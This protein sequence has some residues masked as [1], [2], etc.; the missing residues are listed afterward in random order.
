MPTRRNRISGCCRRFAGREAL[1][2]PSN[3]WR[4]AGAQRRELRNGQFVPDKSNGL[5]GGIAV[6]DALV[7]EYMGLAMAALCVVV[8]AVPSRRPPARQI[9]DI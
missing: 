8:L 6:F 4:G 5:M 2:L 1:T 3:I 9:R 7:F